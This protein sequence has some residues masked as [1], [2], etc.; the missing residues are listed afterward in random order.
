M[1]A[2]ILLAPTG[3]KPT[4]TNDPQRSSLN[5]RHPHGAFLRSLVFSLDFFL[6]ITAL[7]QLKPASRSLLIEALGADS[8]PYVWIGSAVALLA[9]I[10]VY[11]KM[12]DRFGRVRVV[13]LSCLFFAGSL[14]AF[15]MLAATHA[16][17]V[18]VAFY[19]FVDIFGVVLAEQFWSLAD[20]SY[21]TEEG[22]HWYGFVG[23]GGLVGGV[24]G[25]VLAALLIRYTPVQTPD[26]MLVAAAFV[27]LILGLTWAMDQWGL[28]RRTGESTP[29]VALAPKA[30]NWRLIAGNRYLMLIAVAL[31][32]AQ[33][34]SPLVEYQFLLIIEVAYP[35]R[36]ARTAA[37]SLFFSILGGVS[38]A[39]NLVLTPLI[40]NYLGVLAGLLVQPVALA[41]STG[42]F[43]LQPT[44]IPAA[45]MKIT[46]RGLSYSINRAAKELL[47]I[48]VEPLLM[49]QAKAWIDMFGYR[50]FK[51][52]G[53]LIII[54]LTHRSLVGEGVADLGWVTL[55][56]CVIWAWVL[57]IL[58]R[59][60][61]ALTR[62]GAK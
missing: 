34:I 33:A 10:A 41:L 32:L 50:L 15:R 42:G 18:A 37:L 22:R 8:L 38:I 2:R 20:G 61:L 49:Y 1:K 29:P 4:M 14:V 40:L 51:A 7:Y 56:G 53:S 43:M 5:P 11:R 57:V 12:L 54:A 3:H 48:P 39:V 52:L 27:G 45:I 6:I 55:V 60:Y 13:L 16:S 28:L 44:L 62:P 46:D 30:G 25:S 36:E 17:W 58:H 24:F 23:T 19:I 59:T 9:S 21:S 35:E 47:Y 26:L 31:L